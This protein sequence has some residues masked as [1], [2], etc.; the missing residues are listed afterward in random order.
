MEIGTNLTDDLVFKLHI[1]AIFD[2]CYYMIQ[3]YRNI[4]I[5][6]VSNNNN[7]IIPGS[8]T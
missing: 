1:S 7:W 3:Q 5:D 4:H 2:Y 6:D 8:W